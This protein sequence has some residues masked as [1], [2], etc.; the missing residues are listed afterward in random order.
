[1][2]IDEVKTWLSE[3]L[4]GNAAW[5][6]KK[7]VEYPNDRRN[8]EA[9]ES[10]ERLANDVPNIDPA[11]CEA[12]ARLMDD[13][14]EDTPEEESE[15]FRHIGFYSDYGSATELLRSLTNTLQSS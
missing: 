12:Y 5:R 3:R 8:V 10:L 6:H 1:M 2:T 14:P 4:E 15:F 13:P 11:V 7:A 9:A